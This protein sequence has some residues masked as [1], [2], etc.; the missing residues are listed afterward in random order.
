[1]SANRT[2]LYQRLAASP[3]VTG[4]L[5]APDA[6]Y[7][8]IAPQTATG[9]YVILQKQAGTPDWQFAGASVQQE[10]WLVK[11]VH[12]SSSAG[13]AEEIAG[14]IDAAL[15]DAPLAIDGEQLLAVY[16][17]S[18]ITYA[19]ND[20]ADVYRHEGALFRIATA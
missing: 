7:H 14:A 5:A 10:V 9:P 12:K 4:L 8:Q 2:A 20:G 11:A 13:R 19:E 1:M 17:E 3:E 15:T 6:I 18:D 16:R